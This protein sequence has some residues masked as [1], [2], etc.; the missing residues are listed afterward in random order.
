MTQHF[1]RRSIYHCFARIRVHESILRYHWSNVLPKISSLFKIYFFKIFFY[2][3]NFLKN[4]NFNDLKLKHIP[5]EIILNLIIF[6]PCPFQSA[7]WWQCHRTLPLLVEI[8]EKKFLKPN[9]FLQNFQPILCRA[10][11][12]DR[13]HPSIKCPISSASS[14]YRTRLEHGYVFTKNVPYALA[15]Q[16]RWWQFW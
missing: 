1:Q 13:Q 6:Q 2:F 5:V 4:F 9:P 15:S 16:Q 12:G 3:L 14:H 7:I 8:I 11:S 10:I